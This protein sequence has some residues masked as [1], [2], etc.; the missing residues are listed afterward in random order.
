MKQDMFQPE[1]VGTK[2]YANETYAPSGLPTDGSHSLPLFACGTKA[3]EWCEVASG[4]HAFAK[5]TTAG[6]MALLGH[7]QNRGICSG[8]GAL[9][10]GTY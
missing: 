10:G 8:G 1:I 3:D 2:A 5:I 9:D 6:T 4:Q 7:F